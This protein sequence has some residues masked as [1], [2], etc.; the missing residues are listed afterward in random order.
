MYTPHKVTLYHQIEDDITAE[1]SYNVTVLDGVFLDLA[2]GSNISKSGISDA[3]SA[4]LFIPLDVIAYD[5]V[6]MKRKQFLPPKEF[7]RQLNHDQYWTLETGGKSSGSD[8]Y[9]IKG[10]VI[11]PISFGKMREKYDYVY[12][13]TTVDL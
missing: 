7:A 6:T 10:V 12:D 11:D 2:Q 1:V 8:C 3:D 5:P 9:F 13:I 4:T